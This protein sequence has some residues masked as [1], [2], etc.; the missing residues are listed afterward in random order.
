MRLEF[1]IQEEIESK[2]VLDTEEFFSHKVWQDEWDEWDPDADKNN[3][4][5]I[6]DFFNQTPID[7]DTLGVP[8]RDHWS[9]DS[10]NTSTVLNVKEVI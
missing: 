5:D 2:F 6:I 1:T 7:E 10:I 4:D 8:D 9:F 3:P